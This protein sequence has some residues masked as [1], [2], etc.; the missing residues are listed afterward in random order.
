[1]QVGRIK[2]VAT[3]FEFG[4][5][6]K[7]RILKTEYGK[8]FYYP[9]GKRESFFERFKRWGVTLQGTRSDDK[10]RFY[11]CTCP[12][13]GWN[14][15]TLTLKQ[16]GIFPYCRSCRAS[17]D[18]LMKSLYINLPQPKEKIKLPSDNPKP[19]HTRQEPLNDEE[20][21]RRERLRISKF[22]LTRY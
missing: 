18:T 7:P 19:D 4:E 11:Q 20:E 13:C 14:D 1:M 15:L 2:Q 5:E 17:Y 22:H 21:K 8:D 3:Q 6:M 9:T 12:T 16:D 10:K